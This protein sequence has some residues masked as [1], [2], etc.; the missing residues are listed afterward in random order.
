MASGLALI[1]S[2]GP[3]YNHWL[4]QCDS[5]HNLYKYCSQSLIIVY[6]RI[7]ALQEK[8]TS[9]FGR[10]MWCLYCLTYSNIT[11]SHHTKSFLTFV[12]PPPHLHVRHQHTL[13]WL[14]GLTISS[15]SDDWLTRQTVLNRHACFTRCQRM[16]EGD[17]WS[18]NPFDM[19][20]RRHIGHNRY[21]L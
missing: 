6:C 18:C 10:C 8:K 19:K 1:L 3:S 5:S 12:C 14:Y 9:V 20:D 11:R 16:P 13:Q 17:L 4:T 21:T 15:T 2:T 7:C